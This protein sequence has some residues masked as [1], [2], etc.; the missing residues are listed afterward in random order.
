[1]KK[2]II[3][4]LIFLGTIVSA[5]S[6]TIL[7]GK[8]KDIDGTKVLKIL[9]SLSSVEHSGLIRKSIVLFTMGVVP[10]GTIYIEDSKKVKLYSFEI[11]FDEFKNS[12]IVFNDAQEKTIIEKINRII[13][14]KP[15]MVKNAILIP[16][17]TRYWESSNDFNM[18]Y[19]YNESSHQTKTFFSYNEFINSQKNEFQKLIQLF[20]N[21]PY[22]KKGV[23]KELF[24]IKY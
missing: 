5:K 18:Y 20:F 16:D 9:D 12:K 22:L 17:S 19:S 1:M 4:I 23:K 6:Q 2:A 15:M 10:S 24:V 7:S 11:K 13:K 21:A 3:L 14:E 8:Y